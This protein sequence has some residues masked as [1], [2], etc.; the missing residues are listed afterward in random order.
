MTSTRPLP[1]PV[2]RLATAIVAVCAALAAVAWSGLGNPRLSID[3]FESSV[4]GP[5]VYGWAELRND[6]SFEVTIE[7]L[8]WEARSGLVATSLTVAPAGADLDDP[9]GSL[10]ERVAATAPFQPFSLAGGEER[11]V[12]LV[13]RVVCMP[14][15]AVTSEVA[16]LEVTASAPLGRARTTVLEG[17]S[18]TGA[19]TADAC[20]PG[21]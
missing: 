3:H 7:D 21:R 14:A 6:G 4:G 17:S 9:E 19:P 10:A 5:M 16:P 8:T 12:L 13:G 2:L 1:R 15:G 11:V 20:E 18:F